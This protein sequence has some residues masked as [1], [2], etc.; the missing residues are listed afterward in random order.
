MKRHYVSLIWYRAW[1]DLKAEAAQNLMGMTWWVLEPLLYMTAFY[2]I[3]DVF[4]HRGGPGFIGF[5]LCGLVFWRWFDASVK[6][7]GSS[8]LVNGQL[9]NQIYL[10]K[11]VFPLIEVTGN[12]LRF[13]AV[14]VLFLAFAAI[15]TGGPSWAW[16]AFLPLLL[17]ELLLILGVGL[18]LSVLVPVYPDLRKVVDNL[19]LLM[20]YMSGIFFDISQLDA[21]IRD[22]LY[23]NPM[24]VL[25]TEMRSV[26][27][28]SQSP[29][30]QAVAWVALVGFALTLLGFALL[31]LFNRR[32]P[33]YVN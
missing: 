15:Y 24:A 17:C 27:L 30:W 19:L 22:W 29:D 25:I 7:A 10:P 5:L 12:T 31:H 26:L 14:L 13:L 23:L 1:L 4:L 9:I 21:G 2:L 32:L 33:H 18:L 28:Q 11:W 6:R 20:F 8:I 3:F 16:L